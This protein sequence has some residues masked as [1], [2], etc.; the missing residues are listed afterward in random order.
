MEIAFEALELPKLSIQNQSFCSLIS[1][2]KTSGLVIDSGESATSV[3]PIFDSRLLSK[4]TFHPQSNF[5]IR[6]TFSLIL[7]NCQ[8]I[9]NKERSKELYS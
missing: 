5:E 1:E 8:I 2:G 3:V 4:R 9:L 7:R 6:K